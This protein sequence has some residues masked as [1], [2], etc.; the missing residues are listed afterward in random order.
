MGDVNLDFD[1]NIP[2]PETVSPT[3]WECMAIQMRWLVRYGHLLH[4]YVL[5]NAEIGSQFPNLIT[6]LHTLEETAWLV[7]LLEHAL[8]LLAPQDKPTLHL[9]IPIRTALYTILHTEPCILYLFSNRRSQGNAKA[10]HLRVDKWVS[11]Y[12]KSLIPQL[13]RSSHCL[14]S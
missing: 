2:M 3:R 10:T 1:K 13:L 12:F 9:V 4:R 11:L 6:T 8:K 5:S 14:A 7:F